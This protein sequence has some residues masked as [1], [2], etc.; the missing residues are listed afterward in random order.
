[1]VQSMPTKLWMV[2]GA[3]RPCR[4]MA[5]SMIALLVC[6]AGVAEE[7]T[8]AA[9][10]PGLPASCAALVN[11]RGDASTDPSVVITQA[12]FRAGGSARPSPAG[13]T[14][15]PF[16]GH[17]TEQLPA[18]CEVFGRLHDREGAHGQHYAIKFHM[19]LPLEWNGRFAFQGGGGSNGVVGEAVGY[20]SGATDITALSR[21][22]AVVSQD[23]GHDNAVNDDPARQGIGTYGFDFQARRDYGY[24]SQEVVTR[25]AKAIVKAVYGRAPKFSYFLGCSKGGQEGMMMAQRYPTYFDGILSTAPGFTLPKVALSTIWSLQAMGA[26]AKAQGQYDAKGEPLLN[27]AYT[28][29]DLALVSDAVLE[30][31]DGLDGVKDGIVS[32]V[33]HCTTA[34]VA[35]ALAQITC[36]SAKSDSCLT[37]TQVS[38]L[39]RL[40]DGPHNSAGD[41]LYA[42]FP[43]SPGISSKPWRQFFL[44]SYDSSVNTATVVFLSATSM[45]STFSTPPA[46][47]PSDPSALVKWAMAFNFDKD[48]WR[49]FNSTREFPESAW[50]ITS[51]ASLDRTQFR[52]H[53]GKLLLLHGGIDEDFSFIDTARWWASLD[54]VEK[55]KAADFVR[56]FAVPNM[57]HCA[58]GPSTDEYDALTA[59]E[60][61]VEKGKAPEKIIA[62]AG[63][64]SPWPGRT[65]PL[66]A[67]PKVAVYSGSGDVEKAESFSCRSVGN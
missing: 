50:D 49:I 22:Y 44:G 42:P 52:L 12:V 36:K 57:A 34:R 65:R 35:P 43:W 45:S 38:G 24:A 13:G 29:K 48:A 18:H 53:G 51:A 1:M 59:L 25:V 33:E 14:T 62:K 37:E 64:S 28:D 40:F 6:R 11:F 8:S 10:S 41:E 46:A 47:V 66:C 30:A 31:C 17:R 20:S 16:P 27:K 67:Y 2:D 4:L 3:S 61:W 9:A 60:D 7:R 5:A 21:G 56:L 58:G 55:G 23:S 32:D 63:P 15:A 26:V 54:K 39:K 19:R